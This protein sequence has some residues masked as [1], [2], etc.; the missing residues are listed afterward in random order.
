MK[1]KPTMFIGS[2]S[3][4]EKIAR[5]MHSNL[6]HDLEVTVWPDDVFK[7]TKG[8]L[9]SL[10]E[11]VNRF[12]FAA[13][14]L[15]GDDAAT[16]R[17]QELPVVRDNVIL[18]AGMFIGRLG[19]TR[20]FLVVPSELL[21]DK[22]LHLP[23]DLLGTTTLDYEATRSDNNWKAA[24]ASACEDIKGV[25]NELGGIRA[26]RGIVA[27]GDT[28]A[29]VTFDGC[30]VQVAADEQGTLTATSRDFGE[31]DKFE[32]TSATGDITGR[33]VKIG[34]K[35]GLKAVKNS[36]YVGVNFNNHQEKSVGAW[37]PELKLWETFEVRAVNPKYKAG[38]VVPYGV[39]FALLAGEDEAF[40]GGYVAYKPGD[41]HT[42]WAAATGIGD[43]ERLMF[44]EPE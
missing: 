11:V 17:R 1:L 28:T 23:T 7:P 10:A 6:R 15:S 32:I 9:E 39:S 25:T 36:R 41:T 29:L 19:R 31:W 40:A 18:E 22:K 27:Y 2:S 21:D 14:V 34:D 5:A 33:S 43:W 20:V 30:Y 3:E 24:T 38:D 42:F 44:V 16:I 12:D 37:V 13:F 26:S 4:G 8:T 35:I